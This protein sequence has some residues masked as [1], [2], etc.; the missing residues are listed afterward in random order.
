LVIKIAQIPSAQNEKAPLGKQIFYCSTGQ[1]LNLKSAHS[2]CMNVN[3]NKVF[4]HNLRTCSPAPFTALKR[5]LQS[6]QTFQVTAVSIPQE[7]ILSLP[8]MNTADEWKIC[9]GL[10]EKNHPNCGNNIIRIM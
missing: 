1:F 4:P 7:F 9:G 6:L 10:Y 8:V 5:T 3:P 2:T